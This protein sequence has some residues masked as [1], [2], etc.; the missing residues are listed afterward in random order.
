MNKKQILTSVSDFKK[1][2]ELNGYYSD[3]TSFIREWLNSESF[4]L[5]TR[6]RR[7]G[8]TL[9]LSMLK[10]FFDVKEDSKSLFEGLDVA[11][12]IDLYNK[13]MNFY[14]VVSI[15]FKSIK[16]DKWEDCYSK[17]QKVIANEYK[18]HRDVVYHLDEWD[19]KYFNK[20]QNLEG[21]KTDY[22]ES[23]KNL[24]VF[25]EKHYKKKVMLFIDEYD[26][27]THKSYVSGYYKEAIGFF[28]D[29]YEEAMKENNSVEKS[30]MIGILRTFKESIFSGINNLRVITI[31]SEQFGHYFGFT[32]EETESILSYFGK[33]DR[34]SEVK[35]WYNG[36]RFG[37][38]IMYNP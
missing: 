19:E 24:T 12:D 9:M 36:Y 16:E 35:D 28:R 4:S 2:R 13:H 34:M 25:L 20:I 7:F 6:P 21:S 37:N 11:K 30:L 18:R 22:Q 26:T 32:K 15:S 3:K 10:Y 33:E 8:K 1:F 27:P 5:I 14:P 23:L 17:I 29:L 38:H 31:V